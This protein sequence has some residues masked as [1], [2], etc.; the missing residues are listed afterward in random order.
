MQSPTG[1]EFIGDCLRVLSDSLL[2]V[3]PHEGCALLIGDQKQSTFIKQGHELQIQMIWPC[4]N[5]WEPEVLSLVE[6]PEELTTATKE[7]L[8]KE[9]RFVIDPREQLHAQRWA[10]N[11]N[12]SILGCAH[13]HPNGEAI[14]SSI[15][16]DSSFSSRLM[17]I[18]GQSGDLRA[19]RIESDRNIHAKEVAILKPK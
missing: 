18:L 12:L 11:H 13:S 19:W 7:T 10:R 3:A 1:I 15:D 17:V 4:C 9:N 5:V 2:S 14:P 8:S 6:S 16:L